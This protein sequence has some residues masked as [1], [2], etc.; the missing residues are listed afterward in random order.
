M[1][2]VSVFGIAAMEFYKDAIRSGPDAA[3]A[4]KYLVGVNNPSGAAF[5]WAM[6]CNNHEEARSL[7]VAELAREN[8]DVEYAVIGPCNDGCNCGKV[9]GKTYFIVRG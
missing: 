8:D 7:G 3:E 2:T 1:K 6:G 4:R 9:R 5:L